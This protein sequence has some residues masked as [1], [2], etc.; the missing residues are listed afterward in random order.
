MLLDLTGAQLERR[1]VAV[2]S[3][4]I[5]AAVPPTTALRWIATMTEQGLFA[6]MPDPDD[7]RRIFI[8]LSEAAAA[9]MN[10]Y[11]QAARRSLAPAG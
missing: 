6:R 3:L 5:A 8:A 4:C 10:D 2:S 1:R 7:G 11:V 9:A